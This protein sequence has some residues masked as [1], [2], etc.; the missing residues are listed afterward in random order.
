LTGPDGPFE[1]LADTAARWERQLHAKAAAMRVPEEIADRAQQ[2]VGELAGDQ[3]RRLLHGDFH[4]GDV[5]AAQRRSWLAIDPKPWVGDP[6]FDLAQVLLNWTFVQLDTRRGPVDA[7]RFRAA[8]L[9]NR[10]ALDPDRVL[11][12]AAIRAIGWG[13]G[14]DETLTLYEAAHG[15]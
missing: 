10:L 4:P 3:P 6:A 13:F 15:A 11:R 1:E 2:W 7:M 8:D 9:A 14:R 5:L 12:W